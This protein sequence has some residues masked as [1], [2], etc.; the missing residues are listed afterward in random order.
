M[1]TEDNI[2]NQAKKELQSSEKFRSGVVDTK[3]TKCDKPIPESEDQWNDIEHDI[4]DVCEDCFG[5]LQENYVEKKN[6]D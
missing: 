5:I 2:E 1:N 4:Y 6:N 3:C